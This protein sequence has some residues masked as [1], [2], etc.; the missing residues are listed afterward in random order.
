MGELV[1]YPSNGHGAQGYLALPDDP[2][3][4]VIIL[5]EWWGLVPHVKDVAD[6]YAAAGFVALAPDLYD[7]AVTREPDVAAKLM[8]AMDMPRA[9]RELGSA[10]DYVLAQP[11]TSSSGVGVTGFC[12]GGGLAYV[13]AAARPNAVRAVAPFYG[14]IPWAEAQPDY[15]QI[16]GS[17]Q[18][19]YAEHDTRFT[20]EKV[21]AL[22]KQ[23]RDL[24]KDVEFF[25]YPGAHHAFF[26]DTRPEVYDP[27]AAD[28]AWERVTSFLRRR[29][30]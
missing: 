13:L 22:E 23:L 16:T 2:G 15:S 21:D 28:L 10:I 4:G 14:L 12:M 7:G 24:G 26:N 19:H 29:V 20:P 17:I 18:G 3:P 6:R 9:A 30:T 1:H 11:S 5:Q 8:M 25:R 27:Q